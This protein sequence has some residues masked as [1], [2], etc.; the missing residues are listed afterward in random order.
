MPFAKTTTVSPMKSRHEIEQLVMRYGA[1]KFATAVSATK[2]QIMFE[3]KDRMLRFDLK[4]PARDEKRFTHKNS[5]TK[6]TDIQIAALYEQ[7]ERRLWRSLALVIKAKLESV[8][9]G[10]ET[11]ESAFAMNIVMP[12][13]KLFREHALPF[14][15]ESYETG[16]MRPMLLLG[17]G[18]EA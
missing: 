13:G 10:I 11:F 5:W 8:E 14:I 7:E 17:T 1:A 15:A 9:S 18:D 12:D 3:A 6:R 2:A 16:T 4:M